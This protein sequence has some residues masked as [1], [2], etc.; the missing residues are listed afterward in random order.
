MQLRG[1]IASQLDQIRAK[2]PQVTES[3][4]D[5][6]F[7]RVK[8]LL[9]EHDVK[10]DRSELIKEVSIFAERSDIAEE[11]VR[12][13]S[14]LDQFQEI[15]KEP[16]SPGRKLEFLTQEMFR[17]A[18]TIGSKASDVD[19]SRHGGGDQGHTRK[20]SRT[21]AERGVNGLRVRLASQEPAS[22]CLVERRMP[23]AECRAHADET[24]AAHRHFRPERVRQV[25]GHSR[26]LERGDLPLHLSVSATTRPRRANEVGG[27][28]YHY[29]TDDQFGEEFQAGGFLE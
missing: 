17:E 24:G 6:M 13:A 22:R 4:R 7:E 21:G 9:A 18:N 10:I 5:R 28:D 26:L 23:T 8:S 14:H 3:Y 2:A 16:E 15:M 29:W 1:H 20:D 11:V 19:I 25:H 27:K 12:L